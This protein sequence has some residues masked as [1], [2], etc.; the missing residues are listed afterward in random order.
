MH[1]PGA[2]EP[3]AG[4]VD[5]EDE[6]DEHDVH[7]DGVD[8]AGEER[9]LEPA[10]ERVHDDAERDEEAG[11]VDVDARKRVRHGGAA[12]QQHGRDDDVGHEAEHQEHSVRRSAPPRANNL[13]DGVRIGRFALDLDGHDSE[14]EH[15]DGGAAGVPERA[16]HAVLPRHV[17]ALQDCCR[18][19][20]LLDSTRDPLIHSMNS[21]ANSNC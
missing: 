14:Q 13:A 6:D 17:R 15:L 3:V 10:R 4:G 20:P 2:A 7:D 12:E 21:L 18:P 16:A 1:H 19:C 8:V 11:S 9:G 5:E